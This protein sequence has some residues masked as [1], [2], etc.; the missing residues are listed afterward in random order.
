MIK[1]FWTKFYVTPHLPP[2][3][4]LCDDVSKKGKKET[5]TKFCNFFFQIDNLFDD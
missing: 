2:I 1:D 3:F 4:I 5:K